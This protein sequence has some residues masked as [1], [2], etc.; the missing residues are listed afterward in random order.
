M[1]TNIVKEVT[2]ESA[3]APQPRQ[4]TTGMMILASYNRL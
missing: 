1:V 2:N 3:V 4:P